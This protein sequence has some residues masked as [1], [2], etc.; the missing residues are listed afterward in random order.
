M[1]LGSSNVVCRNPPP[2]TAQLRTPPAVPP[3]KRKRL[4]QTQ[5]DGKVQVDPRR[6]AALPTRAPPS[7]LSSQAQK[8]VPKVASRALDANGGRHLEVDPQELICLGRVQGPRGAAGGAGHAGGSEGGPILDEGGGELALAPVEEV[9]LAEEQ[10]QLGAVEDAEGL[11]GLELDGGGRRELVR[12]V[13][14]VDGARRGATAQPARGL[15]RGARLR[16]GFP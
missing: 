11:L 4:D 6:E 10:H 14:E 8:R 13:I 5:D 1:R 7:R 9:A 3:C 15:A 2:G 12:K 16:R